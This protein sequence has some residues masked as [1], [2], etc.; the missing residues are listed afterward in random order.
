MRITFSLLWILLFLFGCAD[1]S[2]SGLFDPQNLSDFGISNTFSS[3]F[4]PVR[5]SRYLTQ[6]SP[7]GKPQFVGVKPTYTPENSTSPY[8]IV[9]C[10][11]GYGYPLIESVTFVIDG[12]PQKYYP[13]KPVKRNKL[14]GD[15]AHIAEFVTLN[16][17]ETLI[18]EILS[19]KKV[20]ISLDGSKYYI[21]PYAETNFINALNKFYQNTKTDNQAV[22]IKEETSVVTLKARAPLKLADNKVN[23]R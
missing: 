22:T 14:S 18:V 9:I 16:I 4:I 3:D 2:A 5:D 10:F 6:K 17:P 23:I 20:M 21:Q 11:D 12:T 7:S 1:I 15:S 8:S 19:A 13:S